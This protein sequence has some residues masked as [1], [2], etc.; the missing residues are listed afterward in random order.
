MCYFQDEVDSD[1]Q[2]TVDKQEDVGPTVRQRR[3]KH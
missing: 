2:T 3:L 1:G